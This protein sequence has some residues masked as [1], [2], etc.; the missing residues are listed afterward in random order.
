VLTLT[1]AL[2]DEMIAHAREQHPVEACGIIAGPTGSDRPTRLIRM[3]NALASPLAYQ[4]DPIEQ[5]AAYRQMDARSED[6]IVICHSHTASPAHPSGTDTRLA[7]DRDACYAIISTADL[8]QPEIRA[9]RLAG[10][11]DGSWTGPTPVVGV[12]DE[13]T[14]MVEDPARRWQW[15]SVSAYL[16]TIQAQRGA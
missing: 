12:W 5:L 13:E 8:A 3:R 16:A 10:P 4:F 9:W 1:A 6:P 14:V 15:P 7:A 11:H 2:V